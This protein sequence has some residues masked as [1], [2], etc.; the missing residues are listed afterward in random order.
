MPTGRLKALLIESRC[1]RW[2]SIRS[3]SDAQQLRCEVSD[4]LERDT[5]E[6]GEKIGRQT[7]TCADERLWTDGCLSTELQ[8]HSMDARALAVLS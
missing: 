4:G 2:H 3:L 7:D 6:G 8:R 1:D 5:T